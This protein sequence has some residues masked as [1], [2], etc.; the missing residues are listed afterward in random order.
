MNLSDIF[1]TYNFPHDFT[2]L[3]NKKIIL[4]GGTG[5]FGLWILS[6]FKFLNESMEIHIFALSRDPNNFLERYPEFKNL[7]WL[8]WIKGDVR[9]IDFNETYYDYI[10]HGAAETNAQAHNNH[11]EMLDTIIKG[12]SNILRLATKLNV[13]KTLL[14]SS[15]AVYGEQPAEVTNIK[16]NSLHAC[17]PLLASSAYGEGKRCMELMGAIH[18]KTNNLHINYAR[19][20]TFMGPGIPID[21]HF[22]FG[23]FVSDI[24]SAQSIN[25]KGDGSTIRS[26]LHGADL[27]VWLVT[28]LL[29]G[30]SNEAYNVGNDEP[31]RVLELAK[32][33]RDVTKTVIPINIMEQQKK[34][35]R[36]ANMYVP[37][38]HKVRQLGCKIQITLE[39]G[40]LSSIEYE[41]TRMP[42]NLTI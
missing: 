29:F 35:S 40:I 42:I 6:L 37:D 25:I 21:G 36:K 2:V 32:K 28:I 17:D 3:D 4:T 7:Q 34:N 15:G 12:G 5:F 11:F 30:K 41:K 8:T 23:N 24:L 31:I 10:I 9:N 26:Y 1:K 39:Q 20:F 27:A 38:I 33:F 22:A 19:C 16:E 18:N 14:I 13:N